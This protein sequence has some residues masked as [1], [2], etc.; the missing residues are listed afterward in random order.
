MA[1]RQAVFTTP[2]VAGATPSLIGGRCIC[3][4]V[5]VPYQAYGCEVCGAGPDAISRVELPGR[6]V[7]RS[8]ALVHRHGREDRSIPLALGRVSLESGPEIDVLI[9]GAAEFE[10]GGKLRA[11]VVQGDQP[12]SAECR[13]VPVEDA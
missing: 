9:D 2:T 10:V 3:G 12:A 8:F 1:E 11:V 5:F 6:G 7:L 4:R 13:F